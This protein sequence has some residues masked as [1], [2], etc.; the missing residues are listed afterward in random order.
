[1]C[2]LLNMT[3]YFFVCSFVF[4]FFNGFSISG[5]SR[6]RDWFC[7][8]RT[9]LEHFF[10]GGHGPT[11][12]ATHPTRLKSV[13]TLQRNAVWEIFPMRDHAQ[14]SRVKKRGKKLGSKD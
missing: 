5:L 2:T 7:A 12:S 9:V 14:K 13:E 10:F 1:M 8:K 11:K 6:L 4:S 3:F